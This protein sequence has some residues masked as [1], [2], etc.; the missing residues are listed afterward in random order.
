MIKDSRDVHSNVT[1]LQHITYVTYSCSHSCLKSSD[2]RWS[3]LLIK[4]WTFRTTF[5]KILSE[6]KKVFNGKSPSN[7]YSML[8][9]QHIS[10]PSYPSI[11]HEIIDD[12]AEW[13]EMKTSQNF[14]R[15]FFKNLE[16]FDFQ[17]LLAIV[18]NYFESM[19]MHQSTQ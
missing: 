11:F 13:R 4:I 14:P 15:I 5:H 3:K 17:M 16:N 10:L 12:G 6:F 18:L 19:L 2:V 9:A 1:I 8:W 7:H